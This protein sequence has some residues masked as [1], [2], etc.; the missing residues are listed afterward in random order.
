[1]NEAEASG[2]LLRS[3]SKIAGFCIP[4]KVLNLQLLLV[5]KPTQPATLS[6]TP[7]I[8]P[9]KLNDGQPTEQSLPMYPKPVL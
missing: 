3:E 4:C 1:L 6:S 9:V 8:K 5:L 2:T 7:Q